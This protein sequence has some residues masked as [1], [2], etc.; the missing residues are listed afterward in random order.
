M[1]ECAAP[2][3]GALPRSRAEAVALGAARYFTGEPCLRGHVAPRG[4]KR[5]ACSI[6]QT[7]RANAWARANPARL[8]TARMKAAKASG[9]KS[10]WAWEAC[11]AAK[12]RAR[13]LGVP[14]ALTGADVLAA[15]VD[16]CPVFGVKLIYTGS[17]GN[18]PAVASVDRIIPEQGYVP[19]NIAVISR[20]ANT[21]KSDATPEDLLAVAAWAEQAR[22]AAHA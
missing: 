18:H 21:I 12:A 11:K 5:G 9:D 10:A 8:T 17:R 3:A 7:L 1:F 14:F 15:A 13:K 2:D 19:G 6:C 16:W 4:V 22:G 20:R